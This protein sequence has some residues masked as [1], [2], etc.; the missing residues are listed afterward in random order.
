M[1]NQKYFFLYALI[2]TLIIFNFGIFMGYKLEASR[3]NKINDWYL[4]AEMQLLDQRIQKDAFEVAGI[5][6]GSMIN[7]N[8]KFADDIFEEAKTISRFEEAN[9]IN[10]DIIAQHKRFDLLRTLLWMNSIKIKNDCNADYHILV[11]LYKYNNPSLEE[12]SKQAVYSNL[13]SQLKEKKGSEIILIPISGDNDLSAVNLL[14]GKYN[15]TELPTILID[16]KIKITNVEDLE[17][18][19]KYLD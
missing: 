2:I 16:E 11:Y 3:I 5:E 4:E 14:M 12:K 17:D 8:I 6:C 18:I 7:E 13:L 9:R 10:D 19:E 15:I 1:K